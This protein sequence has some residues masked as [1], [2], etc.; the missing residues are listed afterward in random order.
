[1]KAGAAIGGIFGLGVGL[2]DG[3]FTTERSKKYDLRP[4]LRDEMVELYLT[5]AF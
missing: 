3:L 4:V 5:M 1:M 2:L